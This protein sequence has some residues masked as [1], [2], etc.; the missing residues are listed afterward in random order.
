MGGAAPLCAGAARPEHGS[1]P[2]LHMAR[3]TVTSQSLVWKPSLQGSVRAVREQ[4][5]TTAESHSTSSAFVSLLE[6][7][8]RRCTAPRQGDMLLAR[9]KI[10]RQ[11]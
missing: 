7:V 8:C 2:S 11:L 5:R 6:S 4:T 10:S 9:T 3:I 1:M